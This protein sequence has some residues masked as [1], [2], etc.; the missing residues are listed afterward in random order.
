MAITTESLGI[1]KKS[2]RGAII[3]IVRLA[4]PDEDGT[5]NPINI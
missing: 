3:G 5:T 2:A 4:C 1:D